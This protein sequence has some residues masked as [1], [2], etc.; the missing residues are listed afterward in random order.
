MYILLLILVEDQIDEG[1]DSIASEQN[2][3]NISQLY[4]G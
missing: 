2:S 4:G 3:T 1:Y